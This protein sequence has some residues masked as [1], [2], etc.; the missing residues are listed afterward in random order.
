[1]KNPWLAFVLNLLLFG[2]GYIYNGKRKMLGFALIIA[3]ILI[4][5]GEITIFLTN[6]VF[7]NWLVLFVGLIVLMFS[8]AFDGYSE[9]KKINEANKR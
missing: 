6:L 8:L 3:W 1:M 2:G 7:K 9:A 4:R 5:Y